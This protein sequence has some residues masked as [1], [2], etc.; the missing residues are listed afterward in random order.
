MPEDFEKAYA[1][2]LAAVQEGKIT[3]ERIDESLERIYRVKCAGKLE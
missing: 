2:V 1:A 3:E